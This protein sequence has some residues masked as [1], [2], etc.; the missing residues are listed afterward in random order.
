MKSHTNG[1]TH[2]DTPPLPEPTKMTPSL[3]SRPATQGTGPNGNSPPRSKSGSRRPTP[4]VG[5]RVSRAST[6][7]SSAVCAFSPEDRE[8]AP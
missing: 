3:P 8:R 2:W 6:G 4:R 7:S 5:G 1:E